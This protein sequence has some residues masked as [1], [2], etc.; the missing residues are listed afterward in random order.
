[1][2]TTTGNGAETAF[3]DFSLEQAGKK[4]AKSSNP[5]IPMQRNLIYLSI[6][7]AGWAFRSLE[8]LSIIS[9]SHELYNNII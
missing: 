4:P 6:T 9:P 2:P 5:R 1:M 7:M 3:P 8:S